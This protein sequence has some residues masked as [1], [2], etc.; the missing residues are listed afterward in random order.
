M[1]GALESLRGSRVWD[2]G[3][4][5]NFEELGRSIDGERQR[6]AEDPKLPMTSA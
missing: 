6:S 1:L 4:A 3:L 2:R 5:G